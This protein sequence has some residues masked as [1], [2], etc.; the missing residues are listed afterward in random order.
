MIMGNSHLSTSHLSKTLYLSFEGLS[1]LLSIPIYFFEPL[2]GQLLWI[3]NDQNK[4]F[5]I[6]SPL[7]IFTDLAQPVSLFLGDALLVSI[8]G[9]QN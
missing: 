7:V 3:I 5:S 4:A 2:T 9:I 8:S 1:L 6:L